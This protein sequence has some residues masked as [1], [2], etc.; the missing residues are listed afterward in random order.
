MVLAGNVTVTEPA[1]PAVQRRCKGGKVE[2]QE[3]QLLHGDQI[4]MVATSKPSEAGSV[5]ITFLLAESMGA[6]TQAQAQLQL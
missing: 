4:R 1:V 3:L 5:A 2:K 6:E